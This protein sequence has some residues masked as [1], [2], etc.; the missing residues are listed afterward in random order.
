MKKE[1]GREEGRG[2]RKKGKE[3]KKE[4]K[5]GKKEGKEG[6]KE[7]KEGRKGG[8]KRMKMK[9]RW[10][11]TQKD[12]LY[13]PS[14]LIRVV[15]GM[16]YQQGLR[17]IKQTN[18]ASFEQGAPCLDGPSTRHQPVTSFKAPSST[19][20]QTRALKVAFCPCR[21]PCCAVDGCVNHDLCKNF[22]PFAMHSCEP[23][24]SLLL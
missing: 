20:P 15:N 8:M 19:P 9:Y 23:I 6:R 11:K 17:C 4:G 14:V 2:G 12:E 3:G 10:M 22:V 7:G 18:S 13:Q 16:L 5:E 24:V 1:K 21:P